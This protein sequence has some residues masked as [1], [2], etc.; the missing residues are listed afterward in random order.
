MNNVSVSL[1]GPIL[2]IGPTSMANEISID[3]FL[4]EMAGDKKD[5]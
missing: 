1:V 4:T 3:V 2:V 5:S